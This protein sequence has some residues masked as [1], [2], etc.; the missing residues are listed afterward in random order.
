MNIS[1]FCP[2]WGSEN[3]DFDH[4]CREVKTGGFDGVEMTFYP[5]RDKNPQYYKDILEKYDLDLIAQHSD[6]FHPDIGEH[7]RIFERKLRFL[8]SMDPLFI[9]SQTG[10]DWLGFEENKSL[11]ELADRVSEDC[12]IA[13]IHETHRNKFSFSAHGTRRFLEEM[14]NLRITL[15]IS[16]WFVVAASM[17]DDQQEAV[18]LALRRTAHI[19]SRVGFTE[20]PQVS[21]PFVPYW[22]ETLETHL[23]LWDKAVALGKP[24]LKDIFTITAECGPVPYMPVMPG[25]G[26]PMADQWSMNLKMRDYLDRHFNS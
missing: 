13:I 6:S 11:I 14:P 4:F 3:Q 7:S 10:R 17:L 24:P 26:E 19:H 15:D 8:A 9:N 20:G 23:Q 16:H 2:L 5:G 12:G 22:K 25:S 1:L 18:D 21:D